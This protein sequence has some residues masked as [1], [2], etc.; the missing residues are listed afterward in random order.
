VRV[1]ALMEGGGWYDDL[2]TRGNAP[3]GE[4]LHWT[5]PQDVL[6]VALTLPL[7]P[8]LGL[9]DAVHVAGVIVSPLLH[10]AAV[11]AAGWVVRPLAR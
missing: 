11:L 4:R 5:R 8:L 2:V 1:T 3:Y 10:L 7:W 9:A 6:I